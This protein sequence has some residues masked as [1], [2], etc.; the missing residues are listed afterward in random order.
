MTDS[1]LMSNYVLM[2]RKEYDAAIRVLQTFDVIN[3]ILDR[4]HESE[5]IRMI[6][7]VLGKGQKDDK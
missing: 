1:E 3:D 6:R 5:Q 4:A 2:G 7:I